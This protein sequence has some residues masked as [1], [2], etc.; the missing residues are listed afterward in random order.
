MTS[1]VQSRP[2]RR[3]AAPMTPLPQRANAVAPTALTAAMSA[4][5]A[6]ALLFVAPLLAQAQG[7]APADDLEAR[8]EVVA[9]LRDPAVARSTPLRGRGSFGIG[10]PAFQAAGASLEEANRRAIAE[11]TRSRC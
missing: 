7:Q 5:L 9:G 3:Y 6:A 4:P 10:P 2:G 1:R 11:A 8:A